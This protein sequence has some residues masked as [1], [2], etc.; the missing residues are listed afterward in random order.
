MTNTSNCCYLDYMT[1]PTQ[2]GDEPK[3][4]EQLQNP[5]ILSLLLFQNNLYLSNYNEQQRMLKL[6]FASDFAIGMPK[7]L[8]TSLDEVV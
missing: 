8:D 6:I 7:I 5:P 2:F 1:R 3:K 4:C